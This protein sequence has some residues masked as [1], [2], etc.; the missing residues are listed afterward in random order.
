M[1]GGQNVELLNAFDAPF[2]LPAG[3]RQ[4]EDNALAGQYHGAARL[5]CLVKI[6]GHD[7]ERNYSRKISI[8]SV[9]SS[10][11]FWNPYV[12]VRTMQDVIS[13]VYDLSF[14]NSVETCVGARHKD[15]CCWYVIASTSHG[16]TVR[17]TAQ[18]KFQLASFETASL[19]I[20][21]LGFAQCDWAYK[22]HVYAVHGL[23]DWITVPN[24]TAL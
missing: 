16:F 4:V 10:K 22:K 23:E 13:P 6:F 11:Q 17:L 3:L 15:W 7:S 18:W 20:W 14:S 21:T 24:S 2:A 19:M 1:E 12:A 5:N 9:V 8:Q